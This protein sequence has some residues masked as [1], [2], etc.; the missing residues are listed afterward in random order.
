MK[1]T[2]SLLFAALLIGF[3]RILAGSFS[4]PDAR[5][6]PN[7]FLWQDTCNVYVLRDGDGALLINL[8][9]G[10]VLDHLTEI[11]V[12][13]VDWVLFTDHHREQCQ[14][15]GRLGA[16]REQGTR[17]GAPEAERG[18]FERPES[19]RRMK[20]SLSD[21]YTVHG[22][23]FVRPPIQPIRLD[24]GFA[25]KDELVWRGFRLRCEETK[26]NSPG[27]M[28]YFLEHGDRWLA[29]SG[30]VMG[31]GARM[32]NY[33]DTEWDYSFGA[34]IYALHDAAAWVAG[35]E[36][37][38]M[39]PSHGPIIR[40]ARRQL[41]S[42]Q[43]KLERL[44]QMILRGY[45]ISR[46]AGSD[47]DRVSK[48]T[49]V[50]NIWRVSPHLYKFKGQGFWPNFHMLLA[51]SGHAL[52]VDCGL[53]DESYLDRAL[54]GMR[55]KL[56]LKAIDVVIISHMHGDH[57]L[58]APHLREKWGARIWALDNMVDKCEHPEW[59]DYCAPVQAYGKGLKGV[60]ID[61]A[62]RKSGET[63]DWEGFK[64]TV[65]WMPGQTEFALGV[66]G[67]IDGR[68]VLFTGDN[69]DGDPTNPSQ[70]GHEAIVARNS[71]ILEQGYIY[72]AEMMR[73]VK[74][75]LILAGHSWAI[76][77]PAPLIDRY[78]QWAYDMRD[79]FRSLS[80]EEDYRY[81]FD[82]FWVRAEPY[83][84]TLRTGESVEVKLEVRN[85]HR[86]PQ[87]HRIEIHAPP[88]LSADPAVVEG[89]LAGE[90]RSQFTVRLTAVPDAKPGVRII[91]FDITRD[92]KR[93]GE[94]FDA[95]V[96]IESARSAD[97]P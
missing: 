74:P 65:E 14:G 84:S 67:M 35:Y 94:L 56:G 45:S 30:D 13:Q 15:A 64:L 86:R 23:S 51:D 87:D 88:G 32:N 41:E 37:I 80:R 50:P 48:P 5:L 22:A 18:L 89:R 82:P 63:I 75:D 76:A 40:D 68:K 8:G 24:R 7:L 70:N 17:V 36:P 77:N 16:S 92:G 12:K 33:F 3:G 49:A 31:D 26:G 58:E 47:Q 91:A 73:R 27:G 42:Y 6:L 19:Y 61:R 66:H 9:D 97:A 43:K 78:R 38:L 52:V 59:F 1:T 60:R 29:F 2:T 93:D 81:W 21:A 55:D 53:F 44:E 34:G 72:G 69:I 83:R 85:F 25:R 54:E 90:A 79:T 4:Q 10:S 57:M 28:T 62:I 95:I 39:L 71:G 20:V 46:F 96:D 11:G